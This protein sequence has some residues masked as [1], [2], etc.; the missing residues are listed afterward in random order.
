MVELQDINTI[1]SFLVS[2]KEIVFVI[3]GCLLGIIKFLMSLFKKFSKKQSSV[4]NH[5][6]IN[7]YNIQSMNECQ[8]KV[9]KNK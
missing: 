5:I 1:I 6:T 3:S 7:N 4:I 8:F 2:Y 9:E